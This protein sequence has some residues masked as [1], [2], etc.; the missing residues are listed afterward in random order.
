MAGKRGRPTGSKSETPTVRVEP[1]RCQICQSTEREDFN[2]VQVIEC[3][4]QDAAG[5]PF[6]HIVKRRTRCSNCGQCRIDQTTENRV[7]G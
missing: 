4:G 5:N 2:N 6:T 1:S 3:A 7:G